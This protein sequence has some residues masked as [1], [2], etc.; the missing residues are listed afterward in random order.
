MTRINTVDPA[1]LSDQHL[2]SEFR[3]LPRVPASLK[4]TL[5]KKHPEVFLNGRATI[6]GY[7][8]GTGHV[9]FFYPS[10][11]FLFNRYQELTV[12][13]HKRNFNVNQQRLI[14]WEVFQRNG[15]FNDWEPSIQCHRISCNRLLERIK[16]KNPPWYRYHGEVKSVEFWGKLYNDYLITQREML[17]ANLRC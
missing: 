7:L 9:T 4:K 6:G 5:K 14:E 12:E 15:L 10:G 3:E 16:E 1:I 13:L 8:L 2:F 17:N 11:E